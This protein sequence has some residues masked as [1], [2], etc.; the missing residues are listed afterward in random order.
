MFDNIIRIQFVIQK[1]SPRKIATI[2]PERTG[3]SFCACSR[4][5]V[6]KTCSALQISR[7]EVVFKITRRVM[8]H[9]NKETGEKKGWYKNE[10]WRPECLAE[11]IP[12]LKLAFGIKN[13][14]PPLKKDMLR[15]RAGTPS[16]LKEVW[17]LTDEQI[18]RRQRLHRRAG[19]YRY[20][21][22]QHL[23]KSNPSEKTLK[24]IENCKLKI[25]MA[26]SEL[27]AQLRTAPIM[28]PGFQ[29]APAG[30]DDG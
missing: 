3:A 13:I 7:G 23:A 19:N 1:Q 20:R 9:T 28:E 27:E 30:D 12:I 22:K 17:N 4:Y 6:K 25:E 2:H 10:R 26:Q 18:E 15:D 11:L 5:N 24:A 14:L 29:D 8:M 16:S 21:L